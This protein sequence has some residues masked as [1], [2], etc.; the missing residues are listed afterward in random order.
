MS[1]ISFLNPLQNIGQSKGYEN[2]G[3]EKFKELMNEDNTIIID[4]RTPNEINSGKIERALELD[5]MDRDFETQLSVLDKNATYLIYCRSGRRSARTCSVMHGMG[6][7]SLY[8]LSGG[9]IAWSK[10]N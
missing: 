9:F 10:N 8:N 5:F 6:F 3:L 7:N 1:F 2:I 4:V